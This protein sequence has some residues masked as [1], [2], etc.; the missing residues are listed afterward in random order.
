MA[1]LAAVSAPAMAQDTQGMQTGQQMGQ[2]QQGEVQQGQAQQ[3]QAATEDLMT[4][5]ENN[6]DLS[7]YEKALIASSNDQKLSGEGSFMVFAPSDQAVQRDL[8]VSDAS[9][10]SSAGKYLLEGT[11]V[12]NPQAPAEGSKQTTLTAINGKKLD[13]VKSDSQIMVNGVKVKSVVP[14]TNGILVITDGVV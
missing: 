10:L 14:A 7:M 13:V 11:I 12:E 4:I 3:G 8:G 6:P 5:I 1:V 2:A 9:S